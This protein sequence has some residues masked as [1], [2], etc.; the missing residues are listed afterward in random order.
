MLDRNGRINI[1]MILTVGLSYPSVRIVGTNY[2]IKRRL[3]KP[4]PR[5]TLPQPMLLLFALHYEKVPWLP[6]HGRRREPR[7]FEQIM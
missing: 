4:V 6:V 5:I 3:S 7:A 1:G 2:D